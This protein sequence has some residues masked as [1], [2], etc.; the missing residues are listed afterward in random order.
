MATWPPFPVLAATRHQP[1]I[2]PEIKTGK[3]KQ[4]DGFAHLEED[5]KNNR[6]IKNKR[7]ISKLLALSQVCK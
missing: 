6:T 1:S 3:S 4:Y 2:A 7:Q 5:K